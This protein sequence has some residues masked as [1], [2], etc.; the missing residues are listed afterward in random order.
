MGDIISLIVCFFT[1]VLFVEIW[2]ESKKWKFLI[3]FNK[4]KL[5]LKGKLIKIFFKKKKPNNNS[6]K[7][8]FFI[9][10]MSYLLTNFSGFYEEFLSQ[11]YISLDQ[12]VF[13]SFSVQVFLFGLVGTAFN[14]RN[15]VS[16]LLS[17]EIMFLGLGLLFIAFSQVKSTLVN[18]SVPLLI[19]GISACETALGLSLLIFM[20]KFGWQTDNFLFKN[21]Q[22]KNLSGFFSEKMHRTDSNK[23][24]SV[25]FLQF[26]L[27]KNY[28][29]IYVI[30][31]LLT[32]FFFM[33]I[34][35]FV[36][37]VLALYKPTR[38]KLSSYEC[39]FEPFSDSRGKQDILFYV[40]AILF[41][42]FDIELVFIMPWA[43]N[44][45]FLPTTSYFLVFF[46][47]FTLLVGFAYE[48][49][50]GALGWVTK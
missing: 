44:Y 34:L 46:F 35:V 43:A 39:G 17:I 45:S 31:F 19:L 23:I 28:E 4:F 41:I 21:L 7:S 8:S 13:L 42:L 12:Y 1:G 9:F 3:N 26:F 37:R 48:W 47:I 22:V 10:F 32:S 25:F 33:F 15:F 16:L 40:V 30:F 14:K 20:Y 50:N 27:M 38:Q 2:E 6:K 5:S 11:A 24:Q 18:F 49:K 29:Y 36:T